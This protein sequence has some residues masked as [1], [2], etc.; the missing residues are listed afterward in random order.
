ML[1]PVLSSV[2]KEKR[3]ETKIEMDIVFYLSGG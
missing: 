3:K 1:E 2:N